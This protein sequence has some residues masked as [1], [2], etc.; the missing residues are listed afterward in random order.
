MIGRCE[1]VVEEEVID[2]VRGGLEEGRKREVLEHLG[3]CPSCAELH[4]E[5]AHI[6]E[7]PLP[8]QMESIAIDRAGRRLRRSLGRMERGGLRRRT[9]RAAAVLLSAAASLWLSLLLLEPAGGDSGFSERQETAVVYRLEGESMLRYLTYHQLD[10]ASEPWLYQKTAADMA[11][12]SG[13]IRVYRAP[14]YE[15][16]I[17]AGEGVTLIEI[18]GEICFVI[19]DC[20]SPS[21]MIQWKERMVCK[22]ACSCVYVRKTC[23]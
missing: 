13:E 10:S 6:F 15:K 20:S 7:G 21:G 9:V 3:S 16:R 4:R 12:M 1:L 22:A 23:Q 5:W 8:E 17:Y 19:D 2:L 14:L 11:E 18:D